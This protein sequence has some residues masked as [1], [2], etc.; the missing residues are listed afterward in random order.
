MS[1]GDRYVVRI[2]Q[3][4]VFGTSSADE[5]RVHGGRPP[6][7]AARSPPVRWIEPTGDV[8]GQP[9]FVMD[10]LD[11]ATTDRNDRSMSADLVDDFVRRLDALH[12]TD[13]ASQLDTTVTA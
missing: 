6:S 7:S 3:G 11:G 13:W 2:E 9:F 12:R 8:V 10:F 4:G 5:F 1:G